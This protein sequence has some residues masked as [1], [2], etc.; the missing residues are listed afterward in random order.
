MGKAV[1]SEESLLSGGSLVIE[2]SASS[3]GESSPGSGIYKNI[4]INLSNIIPSS[5]ILC[6]ENQINKHDEDST[7]LQANQANLKAKKH[8]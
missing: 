4:I 1:S 6:S 7:K 2:E 5:E 8:Q 3:G